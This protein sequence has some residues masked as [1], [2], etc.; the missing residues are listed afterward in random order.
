MFSWLFAAPAPQ[1]SRRKKIIDGLWYR[2]C[3]DYG[4]IVEASQK[5]MD[6]Y[7]DGDQISAESRAE[8]QRCNMDVRGCNNEG[9]AMAVRTVLWNMDLCCPKCDEETLFDDDRCPHCKAR[10]WR[11]RL[12]FTLNRVTK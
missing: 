9:E 1:P 3:G 6:D 12:T 10:L 2:T 8:F 11:T 7:E 5:F 4:V